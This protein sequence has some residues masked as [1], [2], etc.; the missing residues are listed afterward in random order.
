MRQHNARVMHTTENNRSMSTVSATHSIQRALQLRVNM[1]RLTHPRLT[2][3]PLRL[4]KHC[5][6]L[7]GGLSGPHRRLAAADGSL[8][9]ML[10]MLM[11]RMMMIV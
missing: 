1:P 10:M 11:M 7:T 2:H 6:R 8:M 9:L 5:R 3:P 4:T